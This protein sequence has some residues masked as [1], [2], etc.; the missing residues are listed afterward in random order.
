[1]KHWLLGLALAGL[2]GCGQSPKTAEGAKGVVEVQ[3]FQGGYGIDF[4]QKAA[5]DFGRES[6]L[7]ITVEGNPR[8]WEQLRPRFIG[9]DPPDLAY[10][11]WG[12]DHWA[13]AEEDQL[14]QL[15]EALDGKP[16]K[17][18]GT[19]RDTFE[20]SILKLGQLDEKQY[21]LPYFFNVLGWWYDPAVFAKHGWKVPQT[22]DDLLV[23]C[24]DIKAAGV[25]P[26]TFQGQYPYYMVEG[27]LLPWV[28]SIGGA[29]AIRSCQ[30]LEPGAW[31]AEPVLQAAQ[32]IATLR[33]RGFFQQG[34]TAL[35]HTESQQAFLQGR[36]AM[37]P[38]GTWLYSEMR[39]VMPAN[40]QMEF[41]LPPVV[42]HGM[43][44]PSAIIIGIEPWMVP[45]A[46]KNP[47]GAIAF[48]KY[49][50]S[51]EKAKQFVE[52]KGTLMAIKGSDQANL[53][54]VLAGPAA[55][56]KSSKQVWAVQYR[57]W[58]TAFDTEMQNALT[59]MVNGQATPEQFCQR[60][61]NAA[62]RTRN[63]QSIAKHRAE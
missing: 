40:A 23:L 10:P 29:E 61:E 21:V 12:M 30:N 47:R 50:T 9:G 44:D 11:G 59:S 2:V 13:L 35:S 49:L 42:N 37:I 54:A 1:M 15:D 60:V 24:E 5:E 26:I 18:E 25:A 8:V 19:W 20:P 31:T 28:M 41:M 51:L 58:Y 56:F 62:Q 6:G 22:W 16:Q 48:F 43:G 53:P 57:Q 4:F 32:M 7:A 46:A 39:D 3:A 52:Q 45:S 55:R 63:D 38:C 17:G 36:A 14:L 27:M 34:A 33:D